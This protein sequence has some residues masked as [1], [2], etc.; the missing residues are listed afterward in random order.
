MTPTFT[1]MKRTGSEELLSLTT[2]RIERY[3]I[4]KAI[5]DDQFLRDLVQRKNDY[6]NLLLLWLVAYGSNDG[7][8]AAALF[9]DIERNLELFDED[10]R[11]LFGRKLKQWS[12]S[13][14]ESTIVELEFAADYIRRGYSVELEPTLPNNRKGEFCI[15]KGTL[16]IYFEVKTIYKKA[17]RK[18][19]AIMDELSDRLDGIERPFA[20]S[21]DIKR[22][23]ARNQTVEA[24]RCIAQQLRN[25]KAASVGQTFSFA[26]P[27]YGESIVEIEAKRL[28]DG[29]EGYVSGYVFGGGIKGDWRDL[30]SKIT[31]SVK[32]LHPDYPG[33]TIV[34]SYDLET[35]EYDI[36]N[37]LFGDLS[38]SMHS[39]E[40]VRG[41][42]RIFRRDKNSR[43]SAA[44]YCEKR[45]QS[46]GYVRRLL[47][48]H[49][50]FAE[51]SLSPLIFEGE[52]VLQWGLIRQGDGT[53]SYGR[54]R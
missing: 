6:D 17:F 25:I 8:M 35:G 3:P 12:T 43:L 29:E 52:D 1:E 23:F 38:I 32:Q 27:Q 53:A 45:L 26:Y 21:I 30:R 42:D 18:D 20:L 33:V 49:N 44:I 24:A 48:Y 37:A 5:Y 50:P 40:P 15:T 11:V 51:R 14:F 2:Q 28:P 46:T 16:K 22:S 4:L 41:Q 31:S 34:A 9:Q 54:V 10:D 36:R 39:D 7:Q 47:V 13:S 19:R